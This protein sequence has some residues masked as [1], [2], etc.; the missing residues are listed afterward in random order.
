[1]FKVAETTVS[2]LDV[3]EYAK[4]MR[5]TVS[6]LGLCCT[7][8]EGLANG[9]ILAQ[10]EC[11]RNNAAH[12]SLAETLMELTTSMKAGFNAQAQLITDIQVHFTPVPLS[13]GSGMD[14]PAM[15]EALWARLRNFSVLKAIDAARKAPDTK[16]APTPEQEAPAS[17]EC[18]AKREGQ[19]AK[20]AEWAAAS[21]S[22]AVAV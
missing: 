11:E 20:S 18:P 12:P 7:M 14:Y 8:L 15:T 6:T 2:Q 16:A 22:A 4:Q 19:M 9:I 17:P 21:D 13:D 10:E 1:M 5:N 3:K